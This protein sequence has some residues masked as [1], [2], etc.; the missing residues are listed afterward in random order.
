MQ[1]G[2]GVVVGGGAH[3]APQELREQRVVGAECGELGERRVDVQR[4]VAGRRRG[5]R[6]ACQREWRAERGAGLALGGAKDAARDVGRSAQRVERG[7]LGVVRLREH[8]RNLAALAPCLQNREQR[9]RPRVRERRED[10]GRKRRRAVG[11][12]QLVDHGLVLVHEHGEALERH[13]PHVGKE[14]RVRGRRRE[15]LCDILL[16]RLDGAARQRA[17]RGEAVIVG[18]DRGKVAEEARSLGRIARLRVVLK[19]ALE[20]GEQRAAQLRQRRGRRVGPHGGGLREAGDVPR[21]RAQRRFR[22]CRAGRPARPG[23]AAR[24]R[25]SRCA[26]APRRAP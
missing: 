11:A 19:V 12:E 6:R 1:R 3:G 23:R 7:E 18:A 8:A 25:P 5:R 17:V 16:E 24:R 15:A 21:R 20:L 14:E 13:G 4:L 9:R 22:R 26:R 2:R 10:L